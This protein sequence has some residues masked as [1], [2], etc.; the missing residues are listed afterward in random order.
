M[1]ISRLIVI[2]A[3]ISATLWPQL[4]EGQ[5]EKMGKPNSVEVT[6]IAVDGSSLFVGTTEGVYLSMNAGKDWNAVNSG[7]PGDAFFDKLAVFGEIV[8]AGTLGHGVF[9]SSNQG[10]IWSEFN[11]GFDVFGDADYLGLVAVT[12]LAAI[13]E[14]ISAATGFGIF[15]YSDNSQKSGRAHV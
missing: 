13:G 7:L 15:T 10:K 11:S 5:W 4:A 8:F 12:D 2:F 3:V 14:N 1:N 9:R 6:D